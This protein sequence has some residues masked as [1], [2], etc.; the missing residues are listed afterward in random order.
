MSTKTNDESNNSRR[1]LRLP[2]VLE[3]IGVSSASI[4]RWEKKGN[5]PKRRK[6]GL[7]SVAWVEAEIDEWCA[8]R[9]GDIPL[10]RETA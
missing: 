1:F 6:L 3:R 4:S 5:F 2:A 7:N 10:D 8:N 9:A